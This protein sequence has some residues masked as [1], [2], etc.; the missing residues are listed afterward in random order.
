MDRQASFVVEDQIQVLEETEWKSLAAAHE[1]GVG[2]YIDAYRKR[3]DSRQ[4]HPVHDF[5]FAY[6]QT[7]RT[8]LRRWR[9]AAFQFLRGDAARGFLEDDRYHETE[10]GIGLNLDRL[11]ENVRERICWVRSL[12]QAAKSRPPR[13]NCFGLHEWAMVYKAKEI[14]HETTPLRLSPEEVAKVVEGSPIRCSHWDAF[15]FFTP[16]ARPLNE[17]TPEA[18]G[19]EENE[20]FGCIHFNMD[21]YRWT[22]KGSPWL[23]SELLRACFELAL[24]ARELDMRASPYDLSEYDYKP[25]YIETAAG[26]EEYREEQQRIYRSGQVL[27]D[28]LMRECDFVLSR[29]K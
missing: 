20:Q 22:Y 4:K 27:A 11:E 9:P 28:R 14:R 29:R 6:Y 17:L 15:R 1:E 10:Y 5:L 8:T 3:R 25:I 26:R 2:P 21:L 13:F 16:A 12:I 7:N 19:R 23:G 24:E 18:E